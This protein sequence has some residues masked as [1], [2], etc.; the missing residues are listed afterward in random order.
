MQIIKRSCLFLLLLCA[1]CDDRAVIPT[2]ISGSDFLPYLQGMN[3]ISVSFTAATLH[4]TFLKQG[5]LDAGWNSY[6]WLIRQ[7]VYENRD[8]AYT[9]LWEDSSFSSK[10]CFFL[11]QTDPSFIIASDCGDRSLIRGIYHNGTHSVTDLLCMFQECEGC[12]D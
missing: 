2:G 9:L 3:K 1:G 5:S 6:I 10:A 7:H 12:Q 8:S 4:H 11:R